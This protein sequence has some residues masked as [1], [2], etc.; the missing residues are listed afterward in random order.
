LAKN[1]AVSARLRSAIR[2]LRT[3]HRL[4]RRDDVD[5]HMLSDF[6]DALNRVR[7]TAW[8]AQQ[9]AANKVA[10]DDRVKMASL[11]AC[12]RVRAAYQVCRS[13]GEDLADENIEFR[14]GQLTELYAVASQLVEHLKKRL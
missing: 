2:E 4:L 9:A 13:V 1:T 6:R 12:E 8:A 7:N 14:R 3:L 5:P 11:M 10:D